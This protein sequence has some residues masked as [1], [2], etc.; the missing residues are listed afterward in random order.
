VVCALVWV[1]YRWFVVVVC[2]GMIQDNF[3]E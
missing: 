3:P 1:K 2:D